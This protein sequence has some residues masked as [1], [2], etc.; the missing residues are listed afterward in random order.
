MCKMPSKEKLVELYQSKTLQEIAKIYSTNRTTVSRW[1]K[2]LGIETRNRGGGNNRKVVDAVSKEMLTEMAKKMTNSEIA[3]K[4]G[5]GHSNI[6]RLLSLY[7]IKRNYKKSE[8]QKYNRRVRFL[9][10]KTYVKYQKELNPNNYPRTL[11][12]VDGGYQLD[13]IISVRECFDK[14]ISA[15]WCS[16]K[17]NL[18]MIMWEENLLKRGYK[19]E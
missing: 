10:E 3:E 4:L 16:S 13:H 1:F 6:G 9:T 14:G 2:K 12:G 5:C 19:N 7:G 8:Y 17:E 11:C 18:Q 15:E